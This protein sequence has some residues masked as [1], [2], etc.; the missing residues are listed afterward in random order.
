MTSSAGVTVSGGMMIEVAQF[1]C[2]LLISTSSGDCLAL[3]FSEL[4]TLAVDSRHQP[5][6]FEDPIRVD[7]DQV[8]D[9]PTLNLRELRKLAAEE[10]LRHTN[11]HHIKA[12]ALLG[13]S[14]NSLKEWTGRATVRLEVIK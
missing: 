13:C 8:V 12:A 4:C 6:A 5:F 3:C 14:I 7:P 11:G 1:G 2:H 9:L 10:A